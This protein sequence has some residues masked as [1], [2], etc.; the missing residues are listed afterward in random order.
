MRPADVAR[1]NDLRTKLIQFDQQHR[2][3]PGVASVARRDSL[4]RQMID[5]LHRVDYVRRLRAR[6]I[7]PERMDP[8]SDLF[9]PLKAAVLHL[10]ADNIDEAGW[11]VFLS[12][13]F[14]YHV[15]T[16]WRSTRM[17]YGALG[18]EP[19]TWA[20]TSVNPAAFRQWF[21]DSAAALKPILFGNHRKYESV[22]ADARENLADVVDSYIAW[23]GVNRG[24]GLFFSETFDAQGH[25]P[26]PTFDALYQGMAV[27]R[28]GRTGRFDY[29]T[30]MGKLGAWDV[31][32]P[33]PYFGSATGPVD[34][35]LLL[36]TNSKIGKANRSTLSSQ[37]V[38]LGDFLGVNMQI[39]EDS[40]CNWQKSPDRYIPFRG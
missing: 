19:W 31:D 3:L 25:D 11:L 33:H 36:F 26:R 8:K 18:G 38:E 27:K 40:L 20:R 22:R 14:G 29:L 39:M 9:D 2:P 30:M 35:A 21:I 28:F 13:H 34:G 7:S 37:V 1:E 23:V 16:R 12:T 24:H 6:P 5:S 15:K 10:E 32:P 17:V 4:T